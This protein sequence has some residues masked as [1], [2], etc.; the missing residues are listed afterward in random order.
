MSREV[1]LSARILV[2]R[3]LP[4]EALKILASC[5][6]LDVHRRETPLAKQELI[7]RLRD[8]DALVCQLTQQVDAEVLSAGAKLQVVANVAVGY[9]NIDVAAATARGIVVTNTPG[10][11]D[12]TTADFTWTLLLGVARRVV[13]GDRLARSGKWKGWDLM[14]L[15]GTDVHSKTLGIIG[16][17]R[18]GRRVVQRARAFKMRVL[19]HNQARLPSQEETELGAQWADKE[20]LLRESDF[21]S[22][23]V[24]LTP[25]TR[26]LIGA[27]ELSWMKRTAYLINTSRGS[28]V[29]EAALADALEEKDIAGAG[30]DVFEEEPGIHPK[31]LTLPDV[32]LAP[33]LASASV[34]TRTRIAVMAAENV[35]AMLRGQRPKNL[36]NKEAF[37]GQ[38]GGQ[39]EDAVEDEITKAAYYEQGS[40]ACRNYSQL[41][42]RVRTLSQ[43]VL[44]VN[45]AGILVF[46]FGQETISPHFPEIM[47][48]GGLVLFFLCYLA[49]CCRLALSISVQR[50]S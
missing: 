26:H 45:V 20:T 10:V 49:R 32:V 40:K 1:G 30:L 14:L 11:L 50:D 25:K 38:P 21:V 13:E 43:Q 16:L 5:A 47:F 2:A 37:E 3:E 23:H 8:K 15:L 39:K 46:L 4:T 41:T 42:M 31:L 33:H 7:E 17:G 12:D 28:V 22:L 36:V 44:V 6:E 24:P 27:R 9:D 19:Y 48:Y 35:A 34:E 18:I 29:D